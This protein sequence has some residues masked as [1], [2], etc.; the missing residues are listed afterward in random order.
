MPSSEPLPTAGS[1]ERRCTGIII[2]HLRVHVI[3]LPSDSR[4]SGPPQVSHRLVTGDS[5]R[6]P[7]RQ[8]ITRQ[9]LYELRYGVGVIQIRSQNVCATH[10]NAD[11]RILSVG[12]SLVSAK[13]NVK[14]SSSH[15]NSDKKTVSIG[16]S[17]GT[18]LPPKNQLIVP[19]RV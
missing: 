15:G 16:G 10:T 8:V 7:T 9:V 4:D 5:S 17:D 1:E 6:V 11:L 3:L 19:T 13:S 18:L 2:E 14:L 12:Q